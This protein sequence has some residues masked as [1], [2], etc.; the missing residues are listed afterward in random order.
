[1]MLTWVYETQQIAFMSCCLYFSFLSIALI[2]Q[3]WWQRQLSLP[4]RN[5]ENFLCFFFFFW[6]L[7]ALLVVV[8]QNVT[9]SLQGPSKLWLTVR[10]SITVNVQ[11]ERRHKR[12]LQKGHFHSFG[13]REPAE[14]NAFS[15]W[16]M[17][18]CSEEASHSAS[19]L[20]LSWELLLD[21]TSY[22]QCPF[23]WFRSNMSL[24]TWTAYLSAS[25]CY[26]TE[27]TGRCCTASAQV[28]MKEMG[29]QQ[30]AEH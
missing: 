7:P 11:Q 1:M 23:T 4:V 21:K 17:C 12:Y 18:T 15:G 29:F 13:S 5:A 22:V 19:H 20:S 16:N 28:H 10:V 27:L 14:S 6:L 30:Y 26:S 25:D 24:M 9:E 8:P 3:C 2:L